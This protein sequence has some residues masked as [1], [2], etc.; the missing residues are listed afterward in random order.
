VFI[1]LHLLLNFVACSACI[2]ILDKTADIR[3]LD[4]LR[5]LAGVLG[6]V[7]EIKNFMKASAIPVF[8]I[9]SDF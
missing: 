3:P 5:Y 4:Q 1:F 2:F 8:V 9:F 6:F 7:V